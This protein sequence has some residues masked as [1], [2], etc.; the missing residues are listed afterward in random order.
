M[1]LVVSNR[2]EYSHIQKLHA[3]RY[4]CSVVTIVLLRPVIFQSPSSRLCPGSMNLGSWGGFRLILNNLGSVF[5]CQ[6]L[7][8]VHG[9]WLGLGPSVMPWL[10]HAPKRWKRTYP[11]P[12]P[13]IGSWLALLEIFSLCRGNASRFVAWWYWRCREYSCN[14]LQSCCTTPLKKGRYWWGSYNQ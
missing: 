11:A 2:S 6:C 12:T 9:G 5:G 8:H 1:D 10:E 14:D 7:D 3:I 4:L 13:A